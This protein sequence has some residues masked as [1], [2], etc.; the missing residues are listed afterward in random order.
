MPIF[1]FACLD[2]INFISPETPDSSTHQNNNDYVSPTIVKISSVKPYDDIRWKDLSGIVS[3]LDSPIISTFWFNQKTVWPNQFVSVANLVLN[4]GMNPGLGIRGMH[5]K[6]ITGKNIKVA[7]IDQNL[8]Q[9]LDHMEYAGKIVAYHDVG[10]NQS[11]TF[12]S[13]HAPAVTSLLVGTTIGTAPEARV[14]FAAAP[15]WTADAQYQANALNWIIDEN[16][17]LPEN[18]KIRVV[19]ISAA[20]SGPGSPF[21]K[22]QSSWDAA[23]SRAMAADILVLDCTTNHGITA[24]CYYDLENPDDITLVTPGY[25]DESYSLDTSRL[26]V[27][28]SRRTQAEEYNQGDIGYQYTGQGG[29]SWT[30]PYLAGV[31]AMGWQLRPELTN[32]VMLSLLFKSAYRKNDGNKIINPVAFID[33]V[34]AYGK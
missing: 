8:C 2:H 26:C 9:G 6:G 7:I 19:S 25:P 1:F 14:Y 33:S 17:K 16:T 24:P 28:N 15:S 4:K 34:S 11:A 21:T 22:N 13:M 20:P 23:Y 32:S 5:E 29:L 27:P 31:L 18:D 3:Q 10:C 12:G 30:I